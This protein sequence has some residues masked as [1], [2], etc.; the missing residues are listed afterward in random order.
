MAYYRRCPYCGANNDPSEICDCRDKDE[1]KEATPVAP[2]MTSGCV[3][4]TSYQG[5]KQKS[6]F[7][8][9]DAPWRT[10]I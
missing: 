1:K 7:E 10:M 2:G 6:I 8:R 5:A 3:P 4:I 9:R